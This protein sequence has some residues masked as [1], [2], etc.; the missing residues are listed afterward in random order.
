MPPV[1]PDT[2]FKKLKDLGVEEY[3]ALY[4]NNEGVKFVKPINCGGNG[5]IHKAIL[6]R[7]KVAVKEFL[8]P[9]ASE[10]EIHYLNNLEHENIIEF[11]KSITQRGPN[12]EKVFAILEYCP[13]TLADLIDKYVLTYKS[14]R[15]IVWQIVNGLDYLVE[16]HI[17]HRDLT[18]PN[19]L[20]SEFGRIKIADF[21][22]SRVLIAKEDFK[23]KEYNV[24]TL[25]YKAPEVI[26]KIPY[27]FSIDMW[28]LGLIIAEMWVEKPLLQIDE[29]PDLLSAIE[30]MWDPRPNGAKVFA[31]LE[32]CPRS[33]ADVID[34]YFLTYKNKRDIVWQI[35]NGLEYLVKQ[36]IVH[37]DLTTPNIL[38]SETRRF[39]IA[40]F[41]PSRVLIAKEDFK[42]KEYNVTT[43]WY[44]APEVIKN[45]PYS[46]SIDMW[47][48]GLIIAEMWVEKPLLQI[49]EEPDLLSAIE[50]MWDPSKDGFI[51][52]VLF[53]AEKP[54]T[55]LVKHL[56]QI[57][58]KDRATIDDVKESPFLTEIPEDDNSSEIS[59]NT[60]SSSIEDSVP[61]LTTQTSEVNEDQAIDDQMETEQIAPL[62]EQQTNQGRKRPRV[63]QYKAL[64]QDNE[65][66]KFVKPI[67]CGGNGIIHQATLD[68]RKVAVKEFLY[69]HASEN[70]ISYLKH[71]KH[72]NII[73][74][75]KTITQRGRHWDK[76]FA[77]LEFCPRTLAELIARSSLSYS[78]KKDIVWQIANGLDYLVKQHIVHRDLTPWNILESEAGR[79]KIAD[80]GPSRV[81]F[82]KEDFKAKE[83]NVTAL[84]YK[85]P[86][87]IKKTPYSFAIDMWA[88][89]LI[90][91]ELWVRKPLLPINKESDLLSAIENMWDPNKDRFIDFVLFM[92]ETSVVD[93]VKHLLQI[94]PKDR[95]TIDDVKKSPF[96][97]GIPEN[98]YFANI[99]EMNASD[100]FV[101]PS[102]SS[103][104]VSAPLLTTQTSETRAIHQGTGGNAWKRRGLPAD[105]DVWPGSG[106]AGEHREGGASIRRG[107]HH[108]KHPSQE[109]RGQDSGWEPPNR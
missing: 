89:G 22:P 102:S 5:I 11:I 79:F 52:N 34:I 19:I 13:R 16:Q 68:G 38:E 82:A 37:R 53:M 32:Y 103:S 39:K 94:E 10:N 2:L 63:E 12:G 106:R 55:D 61:L 49:D 66:V 95:A 85:A 84:W 99:F 1:D 65:G 75:V 78:Y 107:S 86:E 80:F 20:E 31:I 7:R 74:F 73:E 54:V 17:V 40:D 87:V 71:L 45:I 51:D 98:D 77:I 30:D 76:V 27:S 36:H 9:H 58:P 101:N 44:K 50:D 92:A 48:L 25:W 57:E 14:K 46:F 64:Y 70:E 88:L 83:Y 43:L 96:L 109:T 59:E 42:A 72:E 108:R 104:E 62:P 93:L 69:P 18:T 81:L 35:V 4:N 47:S 56:L 100:V 3:K 60:S 67:N 29:E 33:L 23:A 6:N 21:G 41:G 105:E 91:A 26:K 8:S 24:T 15:D 97:T 90:I 28:S